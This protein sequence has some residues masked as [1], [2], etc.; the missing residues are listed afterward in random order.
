MVFSEDGGTTFSKPA[1]VSTGHAF[2]Y[3]SVALQ[4]DGS[5]IVSWLEQGGKDGARVLARTV[6]KAG[7]AGPVVEVATGGQMGLG[8]PRLFHSAGGTFIAWGSAKSGS[9]LQ[10]ASLSK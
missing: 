10:T 5:A 3:T 9:K 2:G 4:E 1:L 7:T 6:S 8:Y